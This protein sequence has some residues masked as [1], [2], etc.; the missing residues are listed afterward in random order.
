MQVQEKMNLSW[1]V[2]STYQAYIHA[3]LLPDLLY[4]SNE[5]FNPI[6]RYSS[7]KLSKIFTGWLCVIIIR[8][9]NII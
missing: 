8:V 4:Q 5:Q 6:T 9:I 1:S 7:R 2:S 3:S